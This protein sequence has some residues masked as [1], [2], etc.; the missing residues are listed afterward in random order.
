MKLKEAGSCNTDVSPNATTSLGIDFDNASSIVKTADL[1]V[2]MHPDQ[3][4]D[5]IVDAALY[6]NI[7]FFVVPCCTYSREFPH[8]RV[9]LPV[10]ENGRANTT[11]KLVTTYEELVDY[12]QAK[13]PDIQRH[14]LPFEGRNICLYRVAPPK[15]TQEEKRTIDS[16][17]NY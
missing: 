9:C 11:K 15:E 7:S 3:A 13:S 14:V 8:R 10:S 5:A 4:V 1:V 2:G 17:S 6:Q 16:G 12:L